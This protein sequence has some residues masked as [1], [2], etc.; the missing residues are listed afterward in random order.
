MSHILVANDRHWAAMSLS[1]AGATLP[2]ASY[3]CIAEKGHPIDL[4]EWPRACSEAVV[5]VASRKFTQD[6]C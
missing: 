6:Y 4:Q 2:D 5:V 1:Q 3:Q